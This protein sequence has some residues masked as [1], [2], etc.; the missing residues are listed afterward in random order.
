MKH[1]TTFFLI[2]IL[3]IPSLDISKL[4]SKNYA[5][6]KTTLKT[7]VFSMLTYNTKLTWVQRDKW[8]DVVKIELKKGCKLKDVTNKNLILILNNCL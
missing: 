8:I 1:L 3:I 5:E 4:S 6:V 7:A 2:A